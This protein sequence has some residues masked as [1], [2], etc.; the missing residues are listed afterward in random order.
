MT[1]WAGNTSPLHLVVRSLY[2]GLKIQLPQL[3][4][5]RTRKVLD[6]LH[7]DYK[8]IHHLAIARGC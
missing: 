7:T 2:I 4:M 6:M 1:R 3:S 5:T 8:R